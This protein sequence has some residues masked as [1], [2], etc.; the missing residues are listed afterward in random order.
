MNEKLLS[1]KKSGRSQWPITTCYYSLT[2][3]FM[4]QFFIKAIKALFFWC[5]F[6]LH[7]SFEQNNKTSWKNFV[8]S[9]S[10]KKF[11]FPKSSLCSIISKYSSKTNLQ[12]KDPSNHTKNGNK[13]ENCKSFFLSISN[14][15]FV[16][17]RKKKLLS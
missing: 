14:I 1:S 8:R 9:C 15:L 10:S 2:F 5:Y 13:T 16:Y 17:S 7:K 6:L 12:E 3:N 11:F 4:S